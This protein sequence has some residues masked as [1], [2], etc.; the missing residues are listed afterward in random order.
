VKTGFSSILGFQVIKGLPVRRKK[1]KDIN[2]MEFM[3]YMGWITVVTDSVV[4]SMMYMHDPEQPRYITSLLPQIFRRSIFSRLIWFSLE[5]YFVMQAHY[6]ITLSYDFVTSFT[7][8]TLFWLKHLSALTSEIIAEKKD[9]LNSGACVVYIR[10]REILR[11]HAIASDDS[12]R[13]LGIGAVP[14]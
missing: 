10:F 14:G 1:F 9:I 6:M 2:I 8:H 4:Y 13:R 11:H 5:S 7:L 12:F 3:V